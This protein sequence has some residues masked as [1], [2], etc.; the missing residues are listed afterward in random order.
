MS[1]NALAHAPR[2]LWRLLGLAVR[3]WA[4][5][6]LPKRAQRSTRP[7]RR[8]LMFAARVLPIIKEIQA[9]GVSSLRGVAGALTARGVPTAQGGTWVA[10][11]VA[12]VLARESV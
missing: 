5:P 4:I 9:S 6:G 8:P 11:S 3:R 7:V 10:R 1:G 12:D 2:R